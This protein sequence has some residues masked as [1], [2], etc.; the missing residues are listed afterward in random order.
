MGLW[1][2]GKRKRLG[3]ASDGSDE[4]PLPLPLAAHGDA[5]RIPVDRTL[6][7]LPARF[8]LHPSAAPALRISSILDAA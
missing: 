3:V 1:V 7:R 5:S 6:T 4:A 2:H 8:A